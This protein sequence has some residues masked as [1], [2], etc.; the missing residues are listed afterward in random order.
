MLDEESDTENLDNQ[1]FYADDLKH[2]NL[3]GMEVCKG[4]VTRIF[5]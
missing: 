3:L 4:L 2:E 1:N 5:G